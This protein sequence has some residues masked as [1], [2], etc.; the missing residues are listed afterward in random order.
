MNSNTFQLHLA[1]VPAGDAILREGAR[2]ALQVV[3]EQEVEES[4]QR[5]RVQMHAAGHRLVVRNG[6]HPAR[7]LQTGHGTIAVRQPQVTDHRIDED[8]QRMLFTSQI[9]PPYLR[10]TKIVAELV[11]WL[12][13]RGISTSDY[14]LKGRL[15]PAR[16]SN[17][18]ALTCADKPRLHSCRLACK[19]LQSA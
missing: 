2:Q 15:S 16:R 7:N 17:D 12:Y 5:H 6:H 13:L 19:Q 4:I 11:P 1:T 18:S 3:I 10:K 9:L 14:L 8:G